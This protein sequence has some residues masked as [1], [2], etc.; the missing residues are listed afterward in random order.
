MLMRATDLR[1]EYQVDP[2]GLDETEPRF[3]WRLVDDRRGA[4][5]SA[6]QLLVSRSGDG[7][8]WD[9]GTVASDETTQIAYQGQPLSAFD[10]AMWNV[11]V[12]DGD[13]EPSPWSAPAR[14]E[15]GPLS[16][17]DWEPAAFIQS[18]VVGDMQTSAPAPHL[19]RVFSIDRDVVRARLYIT[20]FGLY[21]ATINGRLVSDQ[22]YAPGWTDY[23]RRV[24][25]QALDVTAL[26]QR[27]EN[28]LGAIIGDGWYCGYAGLQRQVWG[29]RPRLLAKLVVELDGAGTKFVVGTDEHWRT[30]T[31]PILASDN[32]NGEIYDA[33]LEITGWDEPGFDDAAWEPVEVCAGF[34]SV[35]L[36]VQPVAAVA[37]PVR[38]VMELQPKAVDRRPDG[39][40]L[41]DFGQNMVGR[42][43]VRVTARAGAELRLRFAEMLDPDG[44]LHVE[45]LLAA[46][47]TDRYTCK[48]DSEET[49]EPRFTF[50]GFRFVE[51]EGADLADDALTGIVL[52]SDA[53]LTGDFSCSNELVNQLHRNIRWSQRGNFLDVPTDCPQRAERMGWT[54]D[55]QVF[56][57]TATYLMDAAAFLAKYVTD[58]RDS[59][60]VG[61]VDR[62]SFPWVVP[63]TF[64]RAGGP[65][66][67]DAGVVVPWVLYERYGDVRQLERHYPAVC[68]YMDFLERSARGRSVGTFLGFGD[69]LSLDP[70]RVIV[71]DGETIDDFDAGDS[72]FGGTPRLFLWHAFDAL[73]TRLAARIAG[74]LGR[75]EDRA[76]FQTR[77]ER[78]REEIAGRYVDANGR[79]TIATQTAYA[80]ALQFDLLSEPRHRR[81]AQADL[82]ANVE[83]VGHLQTGFLGTPH[84][85]EALSNAGRI[86]LAYALLERT[87]HP[88]WLYPVTQGAT[89]IWE[90]WDGWTEKDGFHPSLMNSF[91]HYAY[92]AVG[93]WLYRFVAGIDVDPDGG[94]GYRRILI[95]PHPGGS[96]THASA[97][98]DTHRG[99]IEASWTLDGGAL[100]IRLVV[101][102]NTTATV[103]L[104]AASMDAITERGV[105]LT[106]VAGVSDVEV[107]HDRVACTAGAGEYT[108]VVAGQEMRRRDR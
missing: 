47:A 8:L 51:A 2:L 35:G 86:D 96:L 16:I 64:A 98:V 73:S 54:G 102:P 42:V 21:E 69:W 39:R 83:R 66:W 28:V 94:A 25:Y 61:G 79:L 62:G 68:A 31:G 43:R 67:A 101:P 20:A 50:H 49:Y 82:I 5:Q 30:S 3:S 9:S 85:L 84:L 70:E 78:V 74:L 40:T 107:R 32:Y 80:L 56:A 90:R 95:R 57:R 38:R 63:S 108:F 105:P 91:N 46:R 4:R 24:P 59:Q 36:R 88:G 72:R 103:A 60:L 6:Y 81:A 26:L 97:H 104:P 22:V 1:T 48:G 12:W 65:G 15:L 52:H 19:R 37:P 14:F 17:A 93:E 77:H 106:D 27:G 45:N 99:R 76:R 92:G 55:I 18:S 23:H 10:E 53:A 58:L 89:T 11:R 87:E 29:D 33:R 41:F 44:S 7:D 13:G 71:D 75:E 100:K 34:T